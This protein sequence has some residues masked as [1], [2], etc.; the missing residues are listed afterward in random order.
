MSRNPKKTRNKL[1]TGL[2]EWEFAWK[3]REA[4]ANADTHI[5]SFNFNVVSEIWWSRGLDAGA[6]AKP[7]PFLAWDRIPVRAVTI[8]PVYFFFFCHI[9][10]FFYTNMNIFITLLDNV[11]KSRTSA[12]NLS[13]KVPFPSAQMHK[14]TSCYSIRNHFLCFQSV[15]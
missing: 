11:N 5:S 6:E 9:Q 7:D 3:R 10:T 4:Y 1:K 12:G 8:F 2:N 14:M 13:L 15:S